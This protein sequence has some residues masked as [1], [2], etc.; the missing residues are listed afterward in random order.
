MESLSS[1]LIFHWEREKR[2]GIQRLGAAHGLSVVPRVKLLLH[3]PI[4]VLF[5]SFTSNCN[6]ILYLGN[7]KIWTK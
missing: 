1:C 3:V 7:L 2:F 5:G 4:Q 6:S